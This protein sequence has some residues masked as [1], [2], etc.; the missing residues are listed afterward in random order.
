M[1]NTTIRFSFMDS[2][3]TECSGEHQ[4]DRTDAIDM[5]VAALGAEPCPDGRY[6]YHDAASCADYLSSAD[7]MAVL[8]AGLLAGVSM[9]ALYSLWCSA[10]PGE[11]IVEDEPA[12][13]F[14]PGDRVQGPHPDDPDFDV[15][16]VTEVDGERVTVAWDGSGETTTQHHSLLEYEE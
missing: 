2:R 6:R 12:H 13:D 9:S 3:S 1:T 8:G 15:G 10:H 5:A 4:C 7:D 16:S 11:Q 14:E